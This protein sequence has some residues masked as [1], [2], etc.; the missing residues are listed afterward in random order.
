MCADPEAEL[1]EVF[2][3]YYFFM[4]EIMDSEGLKTR[5]TFF[6][7]PRGNVPVF[8]KYYR[9]ME[10][11]LRKAADEI[12]KAKPLVPER[13]ELT[14]RS[15]AS[16]IQWFY[17][18]ARTHANFYE[19]CQLRDR[20]VALA[21]QQSRS[22][23]EIPEA[24]KLFKR[25]HEVL[26]DEKENTEEALPLV[27]ADVRLDPYYGGDHSFSHGAEMIRT[28]LQI[29]DGEIEDFLPGLH[30]RFRAAP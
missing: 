1:P 19:S 29:L 16:A 9:N 18:T 14:F 11:Q 7:S 4:A 5:P 17:R 26:L 28:K 12:E 30:K 8:A 23:E 20:L 13:V 15:E 6:T 24:D 3:G 27:E 22:S 21:A 25:W 10:E 2:N